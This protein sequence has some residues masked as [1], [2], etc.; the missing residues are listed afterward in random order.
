METDPRR[1][2]IGWQRPQSIPAPPSS[3]Q[4]VPAAWAAPPR[5]AV[6]DRLTVRHLPLFWLEF[7]TYEDMVYEAKST[8]VASRPALALLFRLDRSTRFKDD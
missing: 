4:S 5:A 2:C 1:G 3:T 8:F 7:C 6:P